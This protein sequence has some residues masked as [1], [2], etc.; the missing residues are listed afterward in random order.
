MHIFCFVICYLFYIIDNKSVN[1]N[2][3]ITK[4]Q[5]KWSLTF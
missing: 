4:W 5:R 3:I 1:F 2:D